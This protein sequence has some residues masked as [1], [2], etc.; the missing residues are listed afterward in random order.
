M[1]AGEPAAEVGRLL[2]LMQMLR[3]E[4]ESGEHFGR[5]D[6]RGAVHVRLH[7]EQEPVEAEQTLPLLLQVDRASGHAGRRRG[8]D[9]LVDDGEQTIAESNAVIG[10]MI[11]I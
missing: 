9:E 8:R 3:V 4:E 1:N 5:L 2:E 7:E 6:Q 10:G 11:S